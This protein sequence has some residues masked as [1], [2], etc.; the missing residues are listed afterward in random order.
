MTKLTKRFDVVAVAT[1][2]VMLVIEDKELKVLLLKP[3]NPALSGKWALPGGMVNPEESVDDSVRRHLLNKAGVKNVY[4]EQLYAFGEV[5]R[6]PFGRVVSIAYLALIPD[7][8]KIK[9]STSEAYEGISWHLLSQ[10]PAL[11]YDHKEII[12]YSLD[13]LKA[14]IGYTNVI[15]GL[16]SEEF[17]FNQLLSAYELILDKKLDKR[18]FSK[19][20]LGLKMIKPTSK[21]SVVGAHRPALLYRFT[22]K[23]LKLIEIL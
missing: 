7:I 1:D 22:N 9:L 19:K 17:T 16:L 5:Y 12:H 20:V 23:E 13:R 8:N 10:L 18:N 4:L 15:K 6:D 11:A 21:K 3:K 14:K 2:V